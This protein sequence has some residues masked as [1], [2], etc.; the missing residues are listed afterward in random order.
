MAL[1]IPW[2]LVCI[3]GL[4]E[5]VFVSDSAKVVAAWTSQGASEATIEKNH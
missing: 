2:L 5:A 3:P 4:Q 1:G